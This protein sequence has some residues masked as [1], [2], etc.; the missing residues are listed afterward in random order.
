[1]TYDI[2]KTENLYTKELS[3]SPSVA[4]S[5]FS[6]ISKNKLKCL[7]KFLELNETM[8][9]ADLIDTLWLQLILPQIESPEGRIRAY[10]DAQLFLSSEIMKRN[11][12]I[13]WSTTSKSDNL[14]VQL[15]GGRSIR[16][17]DKSPISIF[18]EDSYSSDKITERFKELLFMTVEYA[19]QKPLLRESWL[20]NIYGINIDVGK[21]K[22]SAK[23]FFIATYVVRLKIENIKTKRDYLIEGD[24]EILMDPPASL[25]YKIGPP[26]VNREP[27][28]THKERAKY[29]SL[30]GQFQSIYKVQEWIQ[31]NAQSSN[32]DPRIADDLTIEK[33]RSFLSWTMLNGKGVTAK[34]YQGLLYFYSQMF[35]S[36]VEL[37]LLSF[38]SEGEFFKMNSE[39]LSIF[40]TIAVD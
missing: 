6:K 7:E 32:S 29:F 8:S 18:L 20:R 1:M 37:D 34:N 19:T 21:S 36:T 5:S 25:A 30:M 35:T 40:P 10:N 31:S 9:Y 28:S 14:R 11:P 26:L 16:T 15:K 4:L 17:Y 23:E 38:L 3:E 24:S 13:K 27:L 2:K 39:I 12:E 33:I 22:L